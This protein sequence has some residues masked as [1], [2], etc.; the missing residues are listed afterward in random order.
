MIR[1]SCRAALAG[2]MNVEGWCRPQ[3][4]H[5]DGGNHFSA[6]LREVP[7]PIMLR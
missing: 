3:N 1:D 7:E 2:V 5:D 4:V 6:L